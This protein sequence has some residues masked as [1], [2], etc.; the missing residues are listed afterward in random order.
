MI[1]VILTLQGSR[2]GARNGLVKAKIFL[3]IA[4]WVTENTPKPGV[5]FGNIKTHKIKYPLRV[6]TSCCG[7]AI[8]R[9]SAFIEFYLEPLANNLPSFL[10]DIPI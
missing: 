5:A 10:K 7:T 2:N 9:L 8:E 3:E 6:I 4:Q 1:L